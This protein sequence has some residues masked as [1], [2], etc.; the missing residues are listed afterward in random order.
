ML[1][2][3]IRHSLEATRTTT[4]WW[5]PIDPPFASTPFSPND[6]YPQCGWS[7]SSSCA[8]IRIGLAVIYFFLRSL[9]CRGLEKY[10]RF[11]CGRGTHPSRSGKTGPKTDLYRWSER[12][13]IN[14]IGSVRPEKVGGDRGWWK[15]ERARYKR[16]PQTKILEL[17]WCFM[18]Y[19]WNL[20]W[21][22][23]CSIAVYNHITQK[24]VGV[25]LP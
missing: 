23:L 12:G 25:H 13:M 19:V 8:R 22:A 10:K 11:E 24:T 6:I 20:E 15:C 16:I 5:A 3:G 2:L 9:S 18:W 17:R 7:S 4:C 1:S 14:F 21:Q